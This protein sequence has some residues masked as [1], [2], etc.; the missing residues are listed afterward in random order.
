[1]HF[2]QAV[3]PN[4]WEEVSFPTLIK[5]IIPTVSGIALPKPKE[6]KI[7]KITSNCRNYKYIFGNNQERSVIASVFVDHGKI[8]SQ[9][10]SGVNHFS[11]FFISF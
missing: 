6:G 10:Y 2:P 9:N 1:M 3:L 8:S 7:S 4:E 5:T 11:N